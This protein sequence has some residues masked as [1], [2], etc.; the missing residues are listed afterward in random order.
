MKNNQEINYLANVLRHHK[1]CHEADGDN[2]DHGGDRGGDHSD[3]G[4][5]D[6]YGDDGFGVVM[7]NMI[8]AMTI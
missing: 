6:D 4:N 7:V 1:I 3:V 8:V 2:D 5:G